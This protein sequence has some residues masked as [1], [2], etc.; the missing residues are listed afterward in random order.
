VLFHNKLDPKAPPY[1]AAN[2]GDVICVSN[3]DTAMLDLPIASSDVEGDQ[4]FEAFTE[5]IPAE[6]TR[7]VVILEPVLPAKK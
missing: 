5:R 1:Y 2:D 7:V 6:E 3:F 4:M